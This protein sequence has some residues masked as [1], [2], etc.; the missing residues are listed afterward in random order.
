MRKRAFSLIE[1][2]TV[3]AILLIVSAIVFAVFA[4]GKEASHKT[5]EAAQLRQIYLAIN[6]YE[7]DHDHGAPFSLADL[8]P[9]Y[10]Q[11]SYLTS[12]YDVRRSIKLQDW[13]ANPWVNGYNVDDP[14]IMRQRASSINS[15]FYLMTFR[16]RFRASV[17]YSSYRDRPEVG[18]LT[19]V[20]L[21]KCVPA[22]FQIGCKYSNMNPAIDLGQPANNLAGPLLTI[23][24]DGSIATR[25]RKPPAAG[26]LSFE[27]LF[28][29]WDL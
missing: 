29:F 13:P 9:T 10:I 3:I 7:Q 11:G 1:V 20:G 23:R 25:H 26:T 14:R 15:Y 24:M 6:L 17:S 12:P 19:G 22:E 4:S 8:Q 18:M 27:Q 2:L 21:M 16:S 5:V 28:L